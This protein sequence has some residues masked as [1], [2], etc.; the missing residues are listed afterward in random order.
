M[1]ASSN[2]GLTDYG[3]NITVSAGEARKG[4]LVCGDSDTVEVW[5]W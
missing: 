4:L 3:G 5:I 2:G 1:Q